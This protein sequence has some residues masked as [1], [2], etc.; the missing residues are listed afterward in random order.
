[1]NVTSRFA[2]HDRAGAQREAIE[3]LTGSRHRTRRTGVLAI[4]VSPSR[5]NPNIPARSNIV[6]HE[7]HG[8]GLATL[9]LVTRMLTLVANSPGLL[10]TQDFFLPGGPSLPRVRLGNRQRE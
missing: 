1:M 5:D 8:L 10:G 9:R 2:H 4:E 6:R 7:A 3:S